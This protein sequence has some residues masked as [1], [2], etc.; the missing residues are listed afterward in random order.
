MHTPLGLDESLDSFGL[1][2]A[3]LDL[4][5]MRV[6]NLK[7]ARFG[8]VAEVLRVHQLAVDRAVPLFCGGM[9]ECGVG[10]AFALSV[11]GLR[12]FTLPTHLGP[13]SRYFDEDVTAPI[14]LDADGT[15]AV[16]TGPGIGVTPHRD[17]LR[18]LAVDRVLLRG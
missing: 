3:A 10:R 5:A 11:A 14:E 2:E 9:M 7:P 16:P 18:A 17:R 6:A 13:S 8:T 4:G 12:G 1:F 15:M